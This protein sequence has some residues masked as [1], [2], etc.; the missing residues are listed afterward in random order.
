MSKE[1]NAQQPLPPSWLVVSK[2]AGRQGLAEGW[3]MLV[4]QCVIGSSGLKT[5]LLIK[6]E[7][8]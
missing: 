8:T 1:E 6:K 7:E 3:L 4:S 2:K 5:L